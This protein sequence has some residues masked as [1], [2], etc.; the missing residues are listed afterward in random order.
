M[1]GKVSVP[2]C[3]WTEDFNTLLEM[4][5]ELEIRTRRPGCLID[6]D[7][8][9]EHFDRVLPPDLNSCSAVKQ[10]WQ[11]VKKSFAPEPED[12]VFYPELLKD[13]SLYPDFITSGGTRLQ[14]RY[15][16]DVESSSDGVTLCARKNELNLVNP[17]IL[18]YGVPGFLAQ[19]V[20][21]LFRSL[22]K[23]IRRSLQPMAET[24][25]NFMALYRK[26]Q[27]LTEQPLSEAVR[28]YLLDYLDV[29]VP[30]SVLENVDYPEFLVTKLAILDERNKILKVL[31]SFPGRDVLGS[32]L[33]KSVQGAK[34]FYR[35]PGSVWP[36]G[37]ELPESAALAENDERR[38]YPALIVENGLVGCS[39][40]LNMREAE[41]NH[42]AGVLQLVKLT[43]KMQTDY[44]K[45]KIRI[46]RQ[47]TLSFFLQY[48]EWKE[49]LL[50]LAILMALKSD[51][52]DIRSA[53]RFDAELEY[54]LDRIGPEI[55]K[56]VDELEKFSAAADRSRDLIR[57]LPA[58][59]WT[60]S[61]ASR[62]LDFLFRSGFLR[63]AE[64]V[65]E[66]SRYLR[67][68][69]QRLERAIGGGGAKD[70]AKGENL[71]P[72]V[73]R[74]L[75]ASERCDIAS[76]A[77]LLDFFLLLQEARIASFTPEIRARKGSTVQA[78]S[79]SWNSL[80]LN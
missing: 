36:E 17:H 4:L 15:L 44:W 1:E 12:I 46:S 77:G 49:D 30:V 7:S 75:L 53:G 71:E 14:V 58:H 29:D 45:S 76:H 60:E 68:L 74:F 31:R 70:A 57:R 69:N 10:H 38:I 48:K 11:R 41:L 26:K 19:K 8:V 25:A 47:L 72:F 34:Q 55:L 42:R 80:R 33:S 20:E 54:A 24:T 13:S 66:Y 2:G 73:N 35:A 50:D 64:A 79:D 18:D 65:C 28:E 39:S 27:I 52:S 56:W 22:P 6:E 23:N 5:R 63:C 32:R 51:P 16:F 9:F 67:S 21:H 40:F 3:R 43:A 78:L 61:D 59:S 62:Q 37:M